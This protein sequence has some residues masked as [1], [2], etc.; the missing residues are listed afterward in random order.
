MSRIDSSPSVI[1]AKAGTQCART[2]RL[3]CG[4]RR[5][6]DTSVIAAKATVQC[7]ISVIAA[8]A[9]IQCPV[10]WIPVIPAK[11]GTQLASFAA[12]TA[13]PRA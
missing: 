8:K 13:K 7:P 5:N 11:A 9:A 12:M 4:L 3:D 1:P 6:D 10:P 2:S